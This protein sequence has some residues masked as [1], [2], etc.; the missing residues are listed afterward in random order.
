MILARFLARFEPGRFSFPEF[1]LKD[2]DRRSVSTL[3]EEWRCALPVNGHSHAV[4]PC[5]R[6]GSGP[7]RRALGTCKGDVLTQVSTKPFE[8]FTRSASSA[9]IAARAA[10]SAAAF[11]AAFAFAFSSSTS[12]AV[13]ARPWVRGVMG[14]SYALSA[15]MAIEMERGER[16][17]RE[18]FKFR[19]AQK[20]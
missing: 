19:P 14:M 1:S 16:G 15:M 7:A 13:M 20:V 12:A 9:L 6:L 17:R 8:S 3:E 10:A 4:S 2:R 5:V 18:R 11:T